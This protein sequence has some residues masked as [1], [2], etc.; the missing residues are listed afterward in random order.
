MNT[1]LFWLIVCALVGFLM[2][3]VGAISKRSKDAKFSARYYIR[4]NK[5]V[6]AWNAL[7]VL[8]LLLCHHAIIGAAYYFIVTK[9]GYDPVWVKYAVS[10]L[11]IV[12]GYGGGRLVRTLLNKGAT[13]LGLEDA[14]VEVQTEVTP[15]AVK[16]TT[17]VVTPTLPVEPP[18]P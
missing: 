7:G 4:S 2:V 18:Q 5:W 3:E 6:L 15:D 8:A 9:G 1:E 10:P 12:I 16:T 11:G 17:T 13:K 14:I